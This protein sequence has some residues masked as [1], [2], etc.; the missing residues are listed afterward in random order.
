G[1][2]SR[3]SLPLLPSSRG[4]ATSE[5]RYGLPLG[6]RSPR[7]VEDYVTAIDALLS[8]NV[9]AAEALDRVLAADPDFAL[10]HAARARVLQMGGALAEARS[11]SARASD[12]ARHASPRERGRSDAA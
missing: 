8:A 4:P 3:H 7:V 5:D 10:A 1:K 12:L 2:W 6:S 11:A 9:G